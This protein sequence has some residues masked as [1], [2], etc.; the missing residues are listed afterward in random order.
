MRRKRSGMPASVDHG[1]TTLSDSEIVERILD[2]DTNLYQL[3]VER[4]HQRLRRVAWAIVQDEHEAEDVVQETHV[5]AY[6]HLTQ[7]GGRSLLSTWLTRIAVHEAWRRMKRRSKQCD[8]DGIAGS[9]WKTTCATHTPEDDLLKSE[10]RTVLKQ[11]I[12][13]L[14]ELLRSVFLMRSLN[15]MSAAQIAKSLEITEQTVRMRFLRAQHILRR[16]L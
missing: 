7:F 14:P 6:E 10:A 9:L 13:A 16:A 12:D 4:H 15:E 5:R 1:T 2:G 3:I 8:I 11:E